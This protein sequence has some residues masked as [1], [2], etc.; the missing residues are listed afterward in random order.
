MGRRSQSQRLIDARRDLFS[1]RDLWYP[2]VGQLHRFMVA[3]QVNHDGRGGTAPDSLVWDRGGV[4]KR[5]KIEVR[6]N[7]DI[8]ALPGLPWFS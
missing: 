6:V 3:I 2:I 4:K 5:R 8:A 1:A 7:V